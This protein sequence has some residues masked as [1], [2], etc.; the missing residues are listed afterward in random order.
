MLYQRFPRGPRPLW[1]QAHK[2]RHS[3]ICNCG[4]NYVPCGGTSIL[5]RNRLITI[6]TGRTSRESPLHSLKERK[7]VLPCSSSYFLLWHFSTWASKRG[8]LT[9]HFLFAGLL[10]GAVLSRA[11][12]FFLWWKPMLWPSKGPF[13]LAG[14]G[15]ISHP[16]CFCDRLLCIPHHTHF[17]LKLE[18]P[19]PS[20]SSVSLRDS[21][22]NCP[23]TS[24]WPLA[25]KGR[26][27]TVD[28]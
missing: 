3:G 23:I 7:V 9:S 2:D 6:W 14:L 27:G 25:W 13:M 4:I 8:D 1:P 10:K 26:E 22:L 5:G 16:P 21:N 18:A 28:N 20:I 15:S 19:H 24:W 11:S 17:K 12:V